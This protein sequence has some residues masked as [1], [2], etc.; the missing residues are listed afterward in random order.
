M[1][2]HKKREKKYENVEHAATTLEEFE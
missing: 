2:Y 1:K